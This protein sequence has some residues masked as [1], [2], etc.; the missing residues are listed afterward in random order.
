MYEKGKTAF[1]SLL[2][3]RA[4]VLGWRRLPYFESLICRFVLSVFACHKLYRHPNPLL[5]PCP[6]FELGETFGAGHQQLR[7]CGGSGRHA[8][9]LRETQHTRASA[10][11]PTP[12]GPCPQPLRRNL[13]TRVT[14]CTVTLSLLQLPRDR[15]QE[16]P[17]RSC[18]DRPSSSAVLR[19]AVF[20]CDSTRRQLVA[21]PFRHRPT[22]L[23]S[24]RFA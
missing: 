5:N 23:R 1:Y 17:Y 9:A 3:N 22:F 8:C 2:Q 4:K 12:S 15:R 7:R 24:P 21:H 6:V 18:C 19:S 13:A 20:L 10:C 16:T 11:S 14:P